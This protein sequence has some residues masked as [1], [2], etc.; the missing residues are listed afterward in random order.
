MAD[1]ILREGS[2]AHFRY[3]RGDGRLVRDA[4]TL[5]RIRQLAIPPAWTEVHIAS[6]P[7]AA[8]QAWGLDAKSRKQYR[9]HARAVEQG[10]LRKYYRVRELAKKLPVLR[11]RIRR[12]AASRTPSRRAVAAAVIRLVSE[13]FF[14]IG[15]ER[16]AEEN[17]TFGITT[18]RKRHVEIVEKQAVFTYVGK[19]SIKQ[20]QVVVNRELTRL[21]ERQL[22]SP[23]TR[24]FRYQEGGRWRD[25]TAR[26]VNAYLHDTLSVPFSA[27]DFRT[28]G[29]TL[30]AATVLAEL[31]APHSDRDG[32]GNVATAMR[33]V[34]AEL[35]NTP[36]ICR[37]SYVHPIVIARY[38]DEGE[39]IRLP[40]RYQ[41]RA[42][43]YAHSPEERALI[44]FLDEHFPERRR[45]ARSA[46]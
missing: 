41:A 2:K 10:Q 25:L 8:V 28:W 44:R 24:L 27:K 43:S 38:L 5:E 35:G 22:S 40:A 42:E 21:V 17:K 32:K 7:R 3:R 46:D 33:L 14:R 37:K 16:Y 30:R 29:G 11:Q 20:R 39:T 12:H 45:R 26:D 34:A 9:Y 13:S 15:G 23:G 36:A 31:G 19:R 4:R 18:L 6:G 1:W